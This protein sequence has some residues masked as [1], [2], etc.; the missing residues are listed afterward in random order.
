MN[1]ADSL[2]IA[3]RVA[4]IIFWVFAIVGFLQITSVM[5]WFAPDRKLYIA[6]WPLLID[7]KYFA[8]FEKETGISLQISYFERSEELY[9]KIKATDGKGYDIIFP[10]DYTTALLVKE[11]LLKRL[12]R[13]KLNFWSDLDPRLLDNYF[14]PGNQYSIPFFWG[15]YGIGLNT[16]IYGDQPPRTWGLVFDER[17]NPQH[18][19][20]SDNA[21]ESVLI[22]AQYLFGST[23]SLVH[24][25]AQQQVKELLMRQKKWVDIY[26]DERVDELLAAENNMIA[27]GLSTDISRARTFNPHLLFVI[28]EEGSFLIIDNVAIPRESRN[29][30]LA[31]TFINFLYQVQVIDHHIKLFNMCSPLITTKQQ[32]DYCPN[33]AVFKK[34]HFLRDVISEKAL[35]GLWIDLLAN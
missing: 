35:N 18:V 15:V 1:K 14:D 25:Q 26:T 13:S 33:D 31:Y 6:T 27:L 28:P 17:Y 7:T 8:A 10:S 12:D 9:T 21:R 3:V 2:K 34:L 29:E 24:E 20:M 5:H 11:G 32:S 23:E 19:I 4:I 16:K 30:Q 22:A